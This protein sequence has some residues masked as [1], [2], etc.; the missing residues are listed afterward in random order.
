MISSRLYPPSNSE[1][2]SE[3]KSSSSLRSLSA[4]A[5]TEFDERMAHIGMPQESEK[6][7][8][9]SLPAERGRDKDYG[10]MKQIRCYRCGPFEITR[11]ALAMLHSRMDDDP[12]AWARLSHAIRI[13][14]SEDNWLSIS[15]TNL[16]DLIKQPLP[17]IQAQL[18]YLARWLAAQLRDDRLGRIPRPAPDL[19]AGIVGAV[20]GEQVTRLISYAVQE[21]I[22]EHDQKNQSLGLTPKGWRMVESS[23]IKPEPQNQTVSADSQ[24]EIVSAHCNE[25]GGV[26]RAYKR[27]SH[28]VRGNDGEVSWSDTYDV[29]ECCGC[30][31][32]A[33]RH[34]HWF[35]EWDQFDADPITGQPRLTPGIK[36]TYWP[37]PTTRERPQ[38]IESLD[39]EVLRMVFDE[40][41]DALNAGM[42]ILASI[43]TRTLLDRAMF[44][45][46][47]DPKGGFAGKLKLMFDQGHIGK[48]EMEVL[49]VITD[50][51]SAAAHRGFNPD[52]QT[53]GTI[54]D[55]VENFLH[56]EFV[57]KTA[58]GRV[59]RATPS[60]S[61]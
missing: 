19:L 17:G 53:L 44:L 8:V 29:L 34:E 9:C 22:V 41:Y 37:P 2:H 54:I 58:A 36:V 7:P 5:L 4:H 30:S 26:R 59:K 32:I 16:D 60:R 20:A 31:G 39:D 25:C 18:E 14:T 51:G 24:S 10:E 47:G 40:V 15:S 48:D 33:V 46:I 55:T 11:T 56:R 35:S 27:A 42:I 6:C 57:L 61:K 3:E 50:A 43:G 12:H 13:R 38:W 23:E 52:S 1:N 28:T 49:R 45:R 21:R